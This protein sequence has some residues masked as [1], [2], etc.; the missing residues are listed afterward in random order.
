VSA[1]ALAVFCYSFAILAIAFAGYTG[2]RWPLLFSGSLVVLGGM[3]AIGAIL[4]D[5]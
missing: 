1:K 3:A 5:R 2:Q 4:A